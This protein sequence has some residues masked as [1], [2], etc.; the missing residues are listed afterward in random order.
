MRDAFF[1]PPRG[2]R[3]LGRARSFTLL[4]LETILTNPYR[5]FIEFARQT[6]PKKLQHE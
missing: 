2:A 6:E 3:S 4:P 5:I 1:H